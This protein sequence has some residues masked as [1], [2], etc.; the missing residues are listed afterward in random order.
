VTLDRPIWQ[1]LTS[2]YVA[3]RPFI[4]VAVAAFLSHV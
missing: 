1:S 3:I 4:R 2:C